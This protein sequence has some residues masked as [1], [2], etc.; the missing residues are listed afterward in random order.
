MVFSDK[1]WVWCRLPVSAVSSVSLCWWWI[2]LE[3]KGFMTRS[4]LW[5]IC[6]YVDK[7]SLEKAS[8]SVCCFA[9]SFS[10]KW[11]VFQSS[12][13]W[14]KLSWT[15]SVIFWGDIFCYPL[16][17]CFNYLKRLLWGLRVKIPSGMILNAY[18]TLTTTTQLVAR[19]SFTR[20]S[21]MCFICR[22]LYESGMN[23]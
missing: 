23:H 11:S 10:S 16:R 12:I 4:V 2:S 22:I 8:S 3:G 18:I 19:L 6:L 9:C 15:P 17:V 7:Q 13:I 21:V 5:R 14:G 20:L 1:V